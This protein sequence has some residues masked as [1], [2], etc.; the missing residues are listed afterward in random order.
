MYLLKS[1]KVKV[2]L[3]NFSKGRKG[4]ERHGNMCRHSQRVHSGVSVLQMIQ[5]KRPP[6]ASGTQHDGAGSTHLK[7]LHPVM[8]PPLCSPLALRRKV[9]FTM[10]TV[11]IHTLSQCGI[12]ISGEREIQTHL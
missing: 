6:G 1:E 11:I 2:I 4:K 7:I 3:L 12:F 8:S 5:S 10:T 9:K